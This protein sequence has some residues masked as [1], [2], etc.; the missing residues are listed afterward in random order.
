MAMRRHLRE[1]ALAIVGLLAATGA[2]TAAPPDGTRQAGPFEITA[3]AR[4][5]GDSGRFLR[6][7]NPFGSLP[8]RDYS[9]R[10]NGQPVEVKPIGRR[11]WH[12]LQ[13]P[14]SERPALLVI[15]GPAVHLVVD[16]GPALDIRALAPDSGSLSLQALDGPSG[17]PTPPIRSVLGMD[18]PDE[19]PTTAVPD[20]RWLYLNRRVL[21]DL[22]TLA[23]VPVEPWLREGQGEAVVEMNAS[24]ADAV[25]LS[26]G[27]TRFVLPAEG[28]DFRRGGERF[29]LLMLIDT[30]TGKPEALRLDPARTPYRDLSAIDAAWIATHLRWVTD[31]SGRERLVVR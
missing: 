17:Q 27:R 14:R 25:A 30:T 5:V 7:G 19:P 23:S 6:S 11:F 15:N 1:A 26:P 9:V 31:P 16:A 28:Q 24:N 13:L 20:G 21:L 2:G 8:M 3:H 18:R 12:V 29:H 22:R 10:W 4:R